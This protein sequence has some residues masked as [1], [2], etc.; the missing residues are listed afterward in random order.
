MALPEQHPDGTPE[1]RLKALALELP[2][3]PK[4]AVSKLLHLPGIPCVGES[5]CLCQEHS[6]SHLQLTVSSLTGYKPHITVR[7]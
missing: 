4:P 1:E 3:F 7:V 5:V 6:F 2:P